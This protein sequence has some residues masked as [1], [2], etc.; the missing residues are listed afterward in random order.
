[1]ADPWVLDKIT[2]S[3]G[4]G[5][6]IARAGQGPLVVMLHGFPE[7]WY[8]WRF[9]LRGLSSLCTCVAPYMRGYGT[10]DAPKGVEN[11]AI[12][13]LARDVTLLIQALGHSRAIV[14]GHDWGGAVAWATAQLYPE[15]V[16]RLIV[17]NCPHPAAFHR[18][19][20]TNFRQMARSWYM[21]FFQIPY[22]P[23]ALLRVGNFAL[24]TR[25][26]RGS[27][28]QK[29]AFSDADIAHYREAFADPYSLTAAINYYRALMRGGFL[30]RL[31]ADHWMNR[32]IATPTL[33]IWGERDFALGK[34][35]T[36]GMEGLFSGLFEL[37]YIPDSGHWVQ[38]EK[39]GL[40]N[41]YIESFLRRTGTLPDTSHP[42]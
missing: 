3:S 2:L 37:K 34:E 6:G 30:R 4:L 24:L 40:V 16:E 7:S 15:F 25:L 17:L 10:T 22:I 8:S 42:G 41:T 27:A 20:H 5:M 11:Y 28:V 13:E 26:L 9:Q 21:L 39:P 1:M 35:L 14:M 29:Q 19:L 36:Y 38:Q 32:I 18:Q 23:E 31:P 33:L 12:E